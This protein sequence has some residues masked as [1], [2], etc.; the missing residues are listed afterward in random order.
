MHPK[1][2]EMLIRILE[3]HQSQG[4]QSIQRFPFQDL[5]QY[6]ISWNGTTCIFTVDNFK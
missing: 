5:Q 6:A 4:M 3:M 1:H 2:A